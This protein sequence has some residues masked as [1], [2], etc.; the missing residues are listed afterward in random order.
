[1]SD[2]ESPPSFNLAKGVVPVAA[3]VA[4]ISVSFGAA[5]WMTRIE[6]RL[7]SIEKGILSAGKDRFYRSE[8]DAWLELLKAR[9]PDLDVPTPA[10]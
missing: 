4:I 10:R 1:M 8:F 7:E 9:N 2:T 3:V 5:A 6:M